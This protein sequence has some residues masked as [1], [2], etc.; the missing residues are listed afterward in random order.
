MNIIFDGNYLFHKTF[1]VFQ[2]YY[3]GKDMTEVLGDPENRQVLLRK[4]IIDMCYTIKRFRRVHRV[5][6]V[7]DSSSWRYSLYKDYKYALTRVRDAAYPL[8]LECLD[9]FADFL[10]KKG[11]IVSRVQGAEGDDL[12]YMWSMYFG[13]CRGEKVVIITGDSD[14][15]QVITEE[16]ALFNNNSHN[17]KLYCLESRRQYWEDY[18][19]NDIEVVSVVPFEVLLGKVILGDTSDNIPKI[20]RG[21]GEKAMQKFISELQPYTEPRNVDIVQM[22]QWISGRFAQAVHMPDDAVFK[23]VYSNLK[24]VWLNLAVYD[25]ALIE[26]MLDSVNENAESY[27]YKGEY[28]LESFYGMLIK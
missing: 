27:K 6:F 20:K 12:L 2:T 8:F 15:R 1:S 16:V 28:T 14:I 3:R 22:A 4:C 9:E 21:F 11:V 23:Q 13:F 7:F 17:L 18:F 26:R 25:E 10:K 24:L 5:A 19:D